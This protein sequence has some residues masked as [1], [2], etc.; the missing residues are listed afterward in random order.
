[1]LIAATFTSPAVAVTVAAPMYAS[2][3]L[4]T[5]LSARAT[6][7]AMPN[8]TATATEMSSESVS[9]VESSL[10]WTRTVGVPVTPVPVAVTVLD[11]LT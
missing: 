7:I 8:P 1:M 2:T 6:P 9:V 3:L 11:P 10:A 4:F 5:W